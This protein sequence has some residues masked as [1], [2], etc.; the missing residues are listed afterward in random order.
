MREPR[1]VSTWD[2][3]AFPTLSPILADSNVRSPILPARCELAHTRLG[4]RVIFLAPEGLILGMGRF[5]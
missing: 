2:E 5:R 4:L 1:V 3:Q